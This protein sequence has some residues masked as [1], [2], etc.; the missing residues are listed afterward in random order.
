MGQL[1]RIIIILVGLWLVLTLVKRALASRKNKPSQAPHLAK[2][3][4][5]DHCGVH[6]PESE[7]VHD[8][9]RHYCSEEHQKSGPR[10]RG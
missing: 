7:A 2:M 10:Q 9:D 1:L 3:I 5:C 4:S 6:V 8:G